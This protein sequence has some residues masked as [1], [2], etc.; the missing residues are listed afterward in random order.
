MPPSSFAPPPETP[1]RRRGVE[2]A[3][4]A[5]GLCLC[6][7]LAIG[8]VIG[9]ATWRYRT[10]GPLLAARAVVIPA[11]TTTEVANALAKAGVIRAPRLF[12]LAALA[13]SRAGPLHAAELQFPAHASFA[14]VLAIL[15]TAPPVEHRVTIPEGLTAQQITAL[16]EHAPA[17]TGPARLPAEGWVLPNTYDY[18]YG[19]PRSAIIARAH[20]ALTHILA[21][22]WA[23]RAPD[24]PLSTPVQA[25]TLASIVERETAL[26]GERPRIAAVFEN[27]L[28]LGMKLQA[29]PTAIYAASKGAG[30]L[31]HPLTQADLATDSP[32]NTYRITG[33]PPGPIDAPGTAAITAT[34]H[35]TQSPDLYFVADGLGGHAFSRTL[36]GQNHNITL[37]QERIHS[38]PP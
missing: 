7:A 23:A 32:Y 10:P 22:L 20:A 13:T 34:L 24:L 15:R 28:R 35:P 8:G 5:L 37:W 17:L 11:G 12:A 4:A 2:W 21:T 14:T 19:T 29:D 31:P 25:L 38:D 16:L 9:A 6:A 36:A 18:L 3:L 26:P 1:H 33:L 30:T 27:R